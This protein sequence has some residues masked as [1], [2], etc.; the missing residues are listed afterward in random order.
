MK[1]RVELKIDGLEEAEELMG[2]LQ[3]QLA[4]AADIMDEL[5]KASH[6]LGMLVKVEQAAAPGPCHG[7]E[8]APAGMA[9]ETAAEMEALRVE[10]DARR[11]EA[12]ALREER[13]AAVQDLRDVGKDFSQ[14]CGTCKHFNDDSFCRE[15]TGVGGG[16]CW[17]WRGVPGCAGLV[18]VPPEL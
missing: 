18:E 8:T 17:E 6:R 14:F 11:V 3:E 1:P 16:D 5:Q 15:C 7:D 9:G 10:L 2:R 4:K 13:N 12:E